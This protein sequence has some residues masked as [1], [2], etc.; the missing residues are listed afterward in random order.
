[1]Y[2][3]AERRFNKALA[4]LGSFRIGTL[5]D[6]RRLE[7]RQGIGDP[8]EGRKTIELRRSISVRDST[9]P[10]YQGSYE[11][12]AL[13]EFGIFSP[14]SVLTDVSFEDCVFVQEIDVPDAFVYCLS[15]EY[16]A[17]AMKSL[18]GA[19]SCLQIVD[20]RGFLRLLTQT[21]NAFT[22]VELMGLQPVAYETRTSEWNGVNWGRHPALIKE[23]IFGDQKEV[24]AVWA[25]K[26][27]QPIQPIVTGNW[28][29]CRT[30]REMPV[31]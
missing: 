29:L 19:D 7:H 22:P 3:Y 9:A 6:F 4:N 13:A 18:D 25:P 21:I 1:M 27:G 8:S 31:P 28:R 10:G 5:H 2:K 14:D 24:R 23:P 12:R 20:M 17:P 15:S 30:C 11:Q 16:S 26:F